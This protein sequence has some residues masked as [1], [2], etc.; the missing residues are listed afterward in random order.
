MAYFPTKNP[1]FGKF[2]RALEWKML[3]YFM[4]IKSILRPF[5]IIMAVWYSLWS[6]GIYSPRFWYIV[7][8]KIW[9]PC[10]F[11][12]AIFPIFE[13]QVKVSIRN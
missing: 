5:G 4:T 8:R 9:Q 7:S 13:C 12:G 11:E 10:S 1:N 6:F 2:W 3:I